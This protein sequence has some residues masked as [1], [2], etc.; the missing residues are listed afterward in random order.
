MPGSWNQAL[1]HG[2][3]F[4]LSRVLRTGY[5]LLGTLKLIAETLILPPTAFLLP[6]PFQTLQPQPSSGK[7]IIDL[8]TYRCTPTFNRDLLFFHVV[9]K[10]VVIR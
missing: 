3:D 6:F 7:S 1:R 4:A 9:L 5:R 2:G 10:Y 8:I